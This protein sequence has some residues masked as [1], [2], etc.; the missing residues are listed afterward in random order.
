MTRE[1]MRREAADNEYLH[2]DF[3]GALS[4]GLDY[5]LDQFGPQA[6]DEYLRRFTDHYYGPLKEKLR[7]EGLE[8][9]ENHYRQAITREGGEV[10]AERNDDR[11]T[12]R[13]TKNPAVIHMRENDYPVSSQFVKTVS[14][15][16]EALCEGSD[17]TA[18]LV[19]YDEPTGRYVQQFRRRT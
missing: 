12:V 8:V 18:E 15:V 7:R 16:G 1:V 10:S 19:E 9:L 2:K 3:H 13:M 17:F 6:V 5:L 4:V 14:V 11:L